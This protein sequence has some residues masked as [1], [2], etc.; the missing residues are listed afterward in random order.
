MHKIV[1]Q[2]EALVRKIAENKIAFNYITK[3]V[4]PNVSLATT[5]A[6]DYYEKETTSYNRIYYVLDGT[7]LLVFDEEEVFLHIGDTCFVEKGTT[8][9]MKGAFKAIIVNQPAFGTT[10]NG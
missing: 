8:Y 9:E 3:D 4:S 6:T 5:E 7:L 1:R 2:S 10:R